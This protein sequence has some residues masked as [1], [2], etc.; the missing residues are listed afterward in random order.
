MELTGSCLL[1]NQ[2]DDLDQV[3]ETLWKSWNIPTSDP[4]TLTTYTINESLHHLSPPFNQPRTQ[5]TSIKNSHAKSLSL[6]PCIQVPSTSDLTNDSSNTGHARTIPRVQFCSGSGYYLISGVGCLYLCT[7]EDA[8]IVLC[9][10]VFVYL[11]HGKR[12]GYIL[13]LVSLS[14]SNCFPHCRL[15]F[16]SLCCLLDC[17]QC[18]VLLL[19]V[20]GLIWA[21]VEWNG[22]E[23]ED[24]ML[25]TNDDSCV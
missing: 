3:N 17:L 5:A 18:A 10:L 25:E 20:M 22:L 6:H 11:Y 13:L 19:E 1:G 16:I 23:G 21:E 2:K 7:S 15:R 4:S 8:V 14:H 24:V 12:D 9:E